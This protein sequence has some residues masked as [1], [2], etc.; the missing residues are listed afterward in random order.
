[1]NKLVKNID[2]DIA[3]GLG[4]QIVNVILAVALSS[5]LARFLD[6]EVFGQFQTIISIVALSNIFCIGFNKSTSVGAS[7]DY[8]IILQKSIF[9]GLKINLLVMLASFGIAAYSYW[10]SENLQVAI[11]AFVFPIFGLSF[12]FNNFTH[13][14][15]GKK[16]FL[17][18]RVFL[19]ALALTRLVVLGFVA[20]FYGN[21][22]YLIFADLVVNLLISSIGL[23]LC[24]KKFVLPVEKDKQLEREL[25][26]MVLRF[27]FLSVF[28][29]LSTKIEKVILGL[30]DPITLSIYYVGM[31]IPSNLKG[32]IKSVLVIPIIKQVEKGQQTG[33]LKNKRKLFLFL[34]LFGVACTLGVVLLAKP[35]ILLLFGE[36]FEDSYHITVLLSLTFV[37]LFVQSIIHHF[38]IYNGFDKEIVAIQFVGSVLKI[39]GFAVFIPIFLV[40][41]AIGT[42]V[43]VEILVFVITVIKFLSFSK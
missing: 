15:N 21:L 7:R 11:I 24:Q 17:L 18:F 36:N 27:S 8:D 20:Y 29:F 34:S 14:L 23:Y 41:G 42:I 25:N 4:I 6:Q 43:G 32:N 16:K 33:S 12:V 9:K 39:V 2:T 5:L 19:T 22:Y 1:L 40:Y 31:I 38:G 13:Y 28:N 35:V 3:Y 37:F 10:I 26:K 30:I